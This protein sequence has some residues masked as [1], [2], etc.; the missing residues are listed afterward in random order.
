MV[1]GDSKRAIVA[2]RARF[3]A[4]ALA[5]AGLVAGAVAC[6]DT[7]SDGSGGAAGAASGGGAG[8][9]GGSAGTGGGSAGTGGGGGSAGSSTGGSAG[10]QPCLQ[11]PPPDAGE[12][13]DAEP[14]PCLKVA[15]DA[16]TD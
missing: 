14:R 7:E 1:D 5:G 16:A 8:G 10:A 2:R 11:P 13:V 6:G 4:A 9:S 3:V 15:P 12:D